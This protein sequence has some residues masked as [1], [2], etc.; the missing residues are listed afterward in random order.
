MFNLPLTKSAQA[1]QDRQTL[2]NSD[3]KQYCL[4]GILS[5]DASN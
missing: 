1:T 3:E 2:R 4:Y 5:V